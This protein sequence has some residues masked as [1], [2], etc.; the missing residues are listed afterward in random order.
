MNKISL[1]G[2]LLAQSIA[3]S[4]V[5]AP[6]FT[7][8]AESSAS[9]SS[10]SDG[11]ARTIA[12]TSF[13]FT[14]LYN[15][16]K[17]NYTDALI[18]LRIESSTVSGRE[19]ANPKL[20]AVAWVGDKKQYD[21]KLWS[22]SDCA[23]AGWQLGDFYVTSKRGMDGE[24]SI[25]RAYNLSTGKYVF[26]FTTEPVSVDIAVPKDNIKRY[27]SYL[28]RIRK[29]SECRKNELPE[30]AVGALILSD[31]ESQMD[32]VLFESGDEGLLVSPK[33][34]LVNNKEVKGVPTMS[35]WGPAEFASKSEAV[36]GF[37]VK[38]VFQ[39]GSEAVVPVANDNFDI[40]KATLPK[41]IKLRRVAVE[42][43]EGGKP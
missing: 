5:A 17:N 13:A 22:I 3:V 27:M 31:G 11:V 38:V 1:L 34:S 42:K 18:A 35:I 4:S 21:A 28:A 7:T 12:N 6:A 19:S 39:D 30:S 15:P 24:S 20:D 14:T 26:S 33:I 43:G 37:S 8:K 29:D 16:N 23:D 32:R 41:S 9:E 36:K 2:F 25:L 40:P 10:G